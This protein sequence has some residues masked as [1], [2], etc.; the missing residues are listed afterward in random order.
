MYISLNWLKD[1]VEVDESLTAEDL[2]NLIT[3]KT[4]EVEEV[5][6]QKEAFDK[7]VTGQIVKLKEHPDADRL[8]VCDVNIG[9]EVV[10]IVCGGSNLFE[11]MY[12]AV[13]LPGSKVRWHG[14]GDL[15]ELK[16]AKVRGVSSHGMIV[17]GSEIGVDDP[18]GSDTRVLDFTEDKPTPGTHL[19]EYLGLD[20]LIIE[21]DNKSLTHRPDLW[22]H[23][24]IARELAA[25]TG[26]SLK[27]YN[28]QIAVPKSGKT[29]E[30][31]IE[32]NDLCPRYL[33]LVI[34]NVKVD[35][36]P[37]WL[38][39][40]L[41]AVDHGNYNNIVD[42]TNYVMAEYGQ[43][44]HAFDAREIKDKIVVRRAKNGEKFKD[45]KGGEHK[46]N[47]NMLVI[48]DSE[49][50]VALAGV[51]GG[52]NS[53]IYDDTTTV[54]LEAANFHPGNVRKTSVEIGVRTDAVQR[55]EKSLD[56]KMAEVALK[57]AAELILELCPKAK[58]AGPITDKGDWQKHFDQV[59][60]IKLDPKKVS[61]KIGEEVSTED[62]TKILES[63][64]FVVE[65]LSDE[66][67]VTVPSRRAMKDVR[68]EDDLIEEIARM[69]GYNNI[70]PILPKL[71]TKLPS[72]NSERKMAHKMRDIMSLSNGFDEVYNYSF[73][74]ENELKNLMISEEGHLK[75]DNYLSAEQ[76][77]LRVNMTANLLK[78]A[79]ENIKHFDRFKIY[80]L[81][82]TYKE[83][84]EYFPLEEKMLAGLTVKKIN[85][86]QKKDV[87]F[88]LMK[89][90][91]EDLCETF[92]A[93]KINMVSGV[94]GVSYA[95]PN[96]SV[97]Y[98]THSGKTIAKVYMLHP[99]VAKNFELENYEIALFELNRTALAQLAKKERKYKTIN[100]F[101]AIELDVSVVIEQKIEI[102]KLIE[103]IKN[104]NPKLINSIELFD[105]YMGEHIDADKKAVAFKIVL[106]ALDRTLTDDDL[107]ST[108]Q[109]IFT[110]LE[111]IGGMIRGK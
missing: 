98:L 93:E 45:L 68:I 79:Q 28:P 63:L 102:A 77:H 21:I 105:I 57:K 4:A 96:K 82:R 20:D 64:N 3:Q 35:K 23:Y 60:Q 11:G 59:H 91:V 14:E 66:L 67:L 31:E 71:P 26:K 101:P 100:K 13:S 24:G 81:G 65:A 8:Q 92:T 97:S 1:F 18:N 5:K 17:L 89:S 30:V 106:Q 61:S 16:E 69:F 87:D 73:Y 103:A 15:I 62:I 36:S 27:E 80:E 48:A 95:H 107:A 58:I 51:I 25:I 10:Q 99:Q 86:K 32:A 2:S 6:N 12:V 29:I 108:Q 52:E 22:G 43:P 42:I 33:G 70:E 34:E 84:G 88:Y 74:G 54:I 38:A 111:K 53:A 47:E 40:R 76:T 50:A 19:G 56:P 78:N 85:K 7:M 83:I 104:A 90:I 55:F 41:K 44:L 46:L 72:A 37:E 39:K 109:Q 75:L 49:R 9:N 94:S 110:N